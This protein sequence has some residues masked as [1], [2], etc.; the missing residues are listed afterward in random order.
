MKK[1]YIKV[2][3]LLLGWGIVSIVSGFTLFNNP[4]PTVNLAAPTVRG[5]VGSIMKGDPSF[6]I[7]VLSND[8]GNPG[9]DPTTVDLDVNTA[10]IQKTYVQSSVGTWTVNNSGVVTFTPLSTFEGL[11]SINYRVSSN[12]ATPVVSGNASI[13]IAVRSYP[14]QTNQPSGDPFTHFT[15]FPRIKLY[16]WAEQFYS[17]T[18]NSTYGSFGPN[19]AIRF[20][21]KPPKNY[22]VA[23]T[24][25]YPLILF[26]HGSGEIG[27][28]WGEVQNNEI[29][30]VHGG[31]R[32]L[33]AVNAVGTSTNPK[34]DGFLFY[35]Q[36]R[37][38]G[39]NCGIGVGCSTGWS[40]WLEQVRNVLDI[41]IQHY[42]V[43]PNRIYVHGLSGG[44]EATWNFAREYPDYIAAMH[45]M[46]AS[47]PSFWSENYKHIPIRLSQGGKDTNPPPAFGNGQVNQIRDVYG[48]NIRYSY[49]PNSGHDTWNS[50]YQKSDF[51]PW[52]LSQD[53]TTIHVFKGEKDF[54]PLQ[55]VFD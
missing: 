12:D 42:H 34:F 8:I 53:K 29:Q 52:F 39:Q 54:C 13:R 16:T 32:S 55:T 51:F 2:F 17:Y 35:P 21:L 19:T 44:G 10:G 4:L 24:T 3:K 40:V 28:Y 33:N 11:A 49:Y 50:E 18:Y 23:N 45:P 38:T 30:L 36:A 46:S 14:S 43:D 20:R 5:D 37:Q 1:S 48:G 15:D 6:S 47:G 25:K 26:F 22:N 9:I 41:L 31:Q 7:N 27:D